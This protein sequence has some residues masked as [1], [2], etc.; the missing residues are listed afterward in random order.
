MFIS[1]L[2]YLPT[3]ILQLH[4]SS[5]KLGGKLSQSTKA[6]RLSIKAFQL[7]G[8]CQQLKVLDALFQASC[9][10][11]KD[12]G[13]TQTLADIAEQTGTLSYQQVRFSGCTLKH[14]GLLRPHRRL[15]ISLNQKS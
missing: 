12:I 9:E 15:L 3:D 2:A 10:Q 11:L 6:H 13:D 5:R 7:G 8:H 14:H 1:L 4:I